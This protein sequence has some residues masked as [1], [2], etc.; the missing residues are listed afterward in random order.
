[1]WDSSR[2]ALA[3]IQA[4]LMSSA[5]RC[6]TRRQEFLQDESLPSI[7][8]ILNPARIGSLTLVAVLLGQVWRFITKGTA[9]ETP[10]PEP[11]ST[12]WW[13]IREKETTSLNQKEKGKLFN[14]IPPSWQDDD[15]FIQQCKSP[16]YQCTV[17]A[18]VGLIAWP[19]A[20]YGWTTVL[21]AGGTA[22]IFSEVYHYVSALLQVETVLGA[23]VS[24]VLVKSLDK[25]RAATR[26]DFQ[27]NKVAA[28]LLSL[29]EE[30]GERLPKGFVIPSDLL[31]GVL[32]GTAT[33]FAAGV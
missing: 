7:D 23:T 28:L 8:S 11:K 26:H 12:W 16:T 14:L 21:A 29:E 15:F 2:E 1:M 5:T 18:L 33:G 31:C 24:D 30:V 10:I 32:L 20:W 9:D 6:N 3:P 17:G 13:H 4:A 22:Y 19:L 27:E 25:I